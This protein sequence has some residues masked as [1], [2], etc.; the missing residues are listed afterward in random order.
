[1]T[2]THDTT[3]LSRPRGLTSSAPKRSRHLIEAA[4]IATTAAFAGGGLL[5]QFVTVPH[6]RSMDPAAF[7][8]HFATSGPATGAVLFPI[9][10]TSVLLLGITTYASIKG[11]RPG[12]IPWAMATAGMVGTIVLLPIYFAGANIA[13]LDPDFPL[14]AVP[15]ELTSWYRWNWVR[16]GL[17]V[18]AT[19]VGCAALAARRDDNVKAPSDGATVTPHRP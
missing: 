14:Q 16:T 8:A 18:V 15:G 1:M 13:L 4:A 19:A 9:E 7:L 2:Q 11:R 3:A 12:W 6:W 17:A 5:T 10:V